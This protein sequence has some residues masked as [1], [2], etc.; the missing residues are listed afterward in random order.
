MITFFI[1]RYAGWQ[2]R[3]HN[4]RTSQPTHR[5]SCDPMRTAGWDML[6]RRHELARQNRYADQRVLLG[7]ERGGC[8]AFVGSHCSHCTR[9]PCPL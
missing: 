6:V 4:V 7:D 2:A 3:E 8:P 5:R 1:I 9:V